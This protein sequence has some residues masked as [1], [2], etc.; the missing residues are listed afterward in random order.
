M[1]EILHYRAATPTLLPALGALVLWLLSCFA[2]FRHF[3]KQ[4][5]VCSFVSELCVVFLMI[6]VWGS[7]PLLRMGFLPYAR[8]HCFFLS[9]ISRSN[10]CG[11]L[12]LLTF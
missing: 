9:L 5:A 1:A 6:A 7:I 8:K 12:R 3:I 11:C 4:T 10:H 2:L